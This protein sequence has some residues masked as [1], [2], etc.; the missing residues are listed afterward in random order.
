M[1]EFKGLRSRG[2]GGVSFSPSLEADE[3]L[4]SQ[5]G[6]SECSFILFCLV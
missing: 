1:V 3:V 4:M 2:T 6:D 5:L